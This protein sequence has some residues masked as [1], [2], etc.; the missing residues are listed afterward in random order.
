LL[1]FG[2]LV[3]AEKKFQNG[4]SP[5]DIYLLKMLTMLLA[6]VGYFVLIPKIYN[7]LKIDSETD[8]L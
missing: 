4:K 1:P 7:A 5:S 3:F 6:M 2:L 8:I